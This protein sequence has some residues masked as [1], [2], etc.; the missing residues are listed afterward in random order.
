[1]AALISWVVDT[2]WT[3]A[4]PLLGGYLADVHWGKYKAI[5]LSCVWS[6]LGHALLIVSAAPPVLVGHGPT[7]SLVCLVLGILVS[8]LGS[9]AFKANIR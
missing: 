9:G 8:G 3:Y 7:G 4:T 5:Q 2:F 1:M 6:L